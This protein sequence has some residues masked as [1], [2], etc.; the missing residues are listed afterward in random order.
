VYLSASA[1]WVR[2]RVGA[3]KL[4]AHVSSYSEQ[5]Y[6]A[7]TAMRY[8]FP[9]L[10]SIGDTS[11]KGKSLFAMLLQTIYMEHAGSSQLFYFEQSRWGTPKVNSE[12]R[13]AC[14]L[15]RMYEEGKRPCIG[16]VHRG[17]DGLLW[18]LDCGPST[19]HACIPVLMVR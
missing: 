12:P 18:K 14:T 4:V 1:R 10:N 5:I 6:V 8:A 11:Q 7:R 9:H 16:H 3:A 15:A 19:M 17:S 2:V 13:R